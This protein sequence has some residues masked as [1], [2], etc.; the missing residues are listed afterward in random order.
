MRTYTHESNGTTYTV[1]V[2]A[3][4]DQVEK[5]VQTLRAAGAGE[6]I[7]AARKIRSQADELHISH[8]DRDILLALAGAIERFGQ[9]RRIHPWQG[10][11]L[12]RKAVR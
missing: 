2:N 12:P 8:P 1:F 9:G 3:V 11:R 6:R 10:P 7:D 5:L 4:E